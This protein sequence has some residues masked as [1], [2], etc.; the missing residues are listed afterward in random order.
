[1]LGPANVK[2]GSDGGVPGSFSLKTVIAYLKTPPKM[3]SLIHLLI[4]SSTYPRY[5]PNMAMQRLKSKR[6]ASQRKR[7]GFAVIPQA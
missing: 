4:K 1:M 7:R 6:L 5:I 2:K 3:F